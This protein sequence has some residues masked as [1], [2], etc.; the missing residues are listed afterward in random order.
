MAETTVSGI[1]AR[2]SVNANDAT[3]SIKRLT[4]TLERLGS[5][6][7]SSTSGL[8]K[9]A[10]ALAKLSGKALALP[11]KDAIGSVKSF[12]SRIS[13]LGSMIKRVAMTRALRA[14]IRAVTASFKE[15]INNLYQWSNG[16]GG[17][18]A[19]SMNQ[20]ATAM[21]YF[22]N[23]AG[24][25]AA[26]LIN[27]LAPVLDMIVDK[28]VAALNAI[29]QLF[30]RLTGAS[31][32]TKAT[33]AAVS[34]GGAVSKA[35]GGA[36]KAAKEA[37]RYLAP[38]DELNVLPD[39]SNSG[40]GGGGGGGSGGGGGGGLF[41]QVVQFDKGISDFAD[42]IKA[43]IAAQDWHGLG[44]ILGSKVNE[45]I[46]S[47]DWEGLGT[48]FGTYV[49][50]LFSTK[51]WTLQTIDFT[52]IGADVATFLNNA[53]NQI[54]FAT[55]GASM[56]QKFTIIG[57]AII[58]FFQELDWGKVGNAIGN[59]VRG[60]LSHV[61]TWL[62]GIDWETMG[63][64][65]VRKFIE[66][67]DGL[68]VTKIAQTFAAFIK[69][70]I[71]A[72]WGL[73]KGAAVTTVESILD[74][75]G[76]LP[77]LGPNGEVYMLDYSSFSTESTPEPA[78]PSTPRGHTSLGELGG[79][80]SGGLK[81]MVDGIKDLFGGGSSTP[82]SGTTSS[83]T[84]HLGGGMQ[85]MVTFNAKETRRFRIA[86][87]AY[88]QMTDKTSTVTA[89]GKEKSSFVSTKNKF[90]LLKD[91][92]V[93]KTTAGKTGAS[94]VN[95]VANYENVKDKSAMATVK[96]KIDQSLVTTREEMTTVRDK[97]A[98]VTLYGVANSSVSSVENTFKN[99]KDK[100]VKA[101]ADGN[102]TSNFNTTKSKY[103]SVYTKN[104]TLTVTGSF[105]SA[106]STAISVLQK[107]GGKAKGG[108]FSGGQWHGITSYASGGYPG[109]GGQLFIA[110]EAGPELVGTLNGHTA[111]M[112]NDQIVAS[113][114]AGVADAISGIRFRMTGFG[115]AAPN[116]DG[117]SEEA[118]YRAFKRA[119]DETDF[120]TDTE[121]TL[122][123][124]VLY[125]AVVNR[126][127]AN[128]RMT[129]VNALA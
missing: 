28:A 128:T 115:T 50:A 98:T 99:I 122:D 33:K 55:L 76:S 74:A 26:P 65:L 54:D 95:V 10:G 86:S 22:K 41:E 40:S 3:S 113:V 58:G 110:R 88:N 106:L 23:S 89:D 78:G 45:L 105:N 72:G 108:L 87:E 39:N 34:Y 73:V 35:V 107:Y 17:Q 120:G 117:I 93:T 12:T 119:L 21:N 109:N 69:A 43:A 61:T 83:G 90:D 2:I 37:L 100:T 79:A 84:P 101:T 24:A 121:V 118:M 62:E 92:I 81:E 6:T 49:N 5:V 127:R 124:K 15:G 67:I 77:V 102:T 36:G 20:A 46:A 48:K 85:N 47:I 114:A 116:S 63:S 38:F 19:A 111:V 7:K 42:S 18:F 14:A 126:N 97:S 16:I 103:D 75:G 44:T 125:E 4:G 94:F 1:S 64:D 129:G 29:N 80:F 9:T 104:V 8:A 71:K 25:A 60:A 59:F 11:F 27:A 13:K 82:T 112:N 91:K 57:D 32:W 30:A 31:Y 51:Y 53:I 66:F 56:V 52:T 123:G 96:G 70:V 68:D